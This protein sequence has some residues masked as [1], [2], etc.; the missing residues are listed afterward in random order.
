M[1]GVGKKVMSVLRR[2]GVVYAGVVQWKV[3][4]NACYIFFFTLE[5][6]GFEHRPSTRYPGG[7]LCH[8][9]PP[10][11]RVPRDTCGR[12]LWDIAEQL[13]ARWWQSQTIWLDWWF[14]KDTLLAGSWRYV[15]GAGKGLTQSLGLFT[16]ELVEISRGGL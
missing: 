3:S 1:Y 9:R 14:V 11:L 15:K 2:K 12:R 5:R 4:G 13:T 7:G 10:A 8:P 16:M 6:R